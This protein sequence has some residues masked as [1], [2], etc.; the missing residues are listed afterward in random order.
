WVCG[1]L[2]AVKDLSQLI[3]LKPA[4]DPKA[5]WYEGIYNYAWSQRISYF[6]SNSTTSVDVRLAGENVSPYENQVLF[7]YSGV[8]PTGNAIL[9]TGR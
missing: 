5:G 6:L 8:S 7:I 9:G 2:P 1:L 3:R 4:P